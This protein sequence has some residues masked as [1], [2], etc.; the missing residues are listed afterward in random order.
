MEG[1]DKQKENYR[2]RKRGEREQK[3]GKRGRRESKVSYHMCGNFDIALCQWHKPGSVLDSFK[4]HLEKR[5]IP[6]ISLRVGC[7][8]MTEKAS[9]PFRPIFFLPLGRNI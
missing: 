5:E 2:G 3:K 7:P 1:G 8:P 4:S 9:C 6:I